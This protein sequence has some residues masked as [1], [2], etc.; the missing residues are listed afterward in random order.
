MANELENRPGWLAKDEWAKAVVHLP[1]ACVDLVPVTRNLSGVIDRIGLIRREGSPSGRPI[2][3]HLGGRVL[4]N[5]LLNDAACRLLEDTLSDTG[6]I[7]IALE[8]FCVNQYFRT[9]KDGVGLDFRKHAI[10]SCYL[11]EFDNVDAS[12]TPKGE[13]LD[14]AW[15]TA[16]NLP[17]DDDLWPGCQIMLDRVKIEPLWTESLTTY[18]ILSD[19]EIAHNGL[20]WQTPVLAMT[21]IAFLMTIALGTNHDWERAVAAFLSAAV[22]IVS[23]QLMAKHSVGQISDSN[24]L[25]AIEQRRHMMQAHAPFDR[26]PFA[27]TT[28]HNGVIGWLATKRSRDWWIRALGLFAIVSVI[29]FI[30][31]LFGI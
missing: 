13:A 31:A 4:V 23:I 19:R 9:P 24:A 25:W 20:M 8:P 7:T 1:I 14:F 21:A 5:E 17:T 10:A 2:W 3:C 6:P 26:R 18:G 28:R 16:D 30:L 12:P 15:F 11:V 27:R 29:V 22:A